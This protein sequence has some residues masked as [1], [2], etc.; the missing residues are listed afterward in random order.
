MARKMTCCGVVAALLLALCL[1]GIMAVAAADTPPDWVGDAVAEPDGYRVVNR[2]ERFANEGK[3]EE[4][5]CIWTC[6][7]SHYTDWYIEEYDADVRW[8]WAEQANTDDYEDVEG[9]GGF[10]S[11]AD[12]CDDLEEIFLYYYPG[13]LP[14]D[15]IPDSGHYW[16]D[17]TVTVYCKR[18]LDVCRPPAKE[19]TIWILDVNLETTAGGGP[20]NNDTGYHNGDGSQQD[21]EDYDHWADPQPD[22]KILPIALNNDDDDENRVADKYQTTVA[23]DKEGDLEC[24]TFQFT[25]GILKHKQGTVRVKISGD[26]PVGPV[27]HPK[28]KLW[29]NKRKGANQE[30]VLELYYTPPSAS[31]LRLDV[32]KMT[33]ITGDLT[34]DI[35]G[36]GIINDDEPT[37]VDQTR[38]QELGAFVAVNDDDDD[39][40][41]SVDKD[42]PEVVAGAPAASR[43]EDDLKEFYMGNL[44][45]TAINSE[46]KLRL[47]RS[48]AKIK[49]YDAETKGAGSLLVPHDGK[50]YREWDVTDSALPGWVWVEG[51]TQGASEL[52]IEYLPEDCPA[53]TAPVELDVVKVTVVTIALDGVKVYDPKLDGDPNGPTCDITYR[54]TGAP[55]GTK[56]ELTVVQDVAGTETVVNPAGQAPAAAA[57][58]LGRI[59]AGVNTATGYHNSQASSLRYDI[60]RG[61]SNYTVGDTL[62]LANSR[63]SNGLTFDVEDSLTPQG[64]TLHRVG[65]STAN[66]TLNGRPLNTAGTPERGADAEVNGINASYTVTIDAVVSDFTATRNKAPNAQGA[67][68]V[69]VGGAPGAGTDFTTTDGTVSFEI[70]R[71]TNPFVA[72]DN[73]TFDTQFNYVE[74]RASLAA[75][76]AAGRTPCNWSGAVAVTAC[77]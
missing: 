24:L 52:K 36:D 57:N 30:V 72:V 19:R 68:T 16:C 2:T 12:D 23:D 74:Y 56:G 50:D 26:D 8:S 10:G 54:V 39:R 46:G 38:E 31:E 55:A 17:G 43:D 28:L 29:K 34:T 71:G 60:I 65:G 48:N 18:P 9:E 5:D 27:L 75:P 3:A 32:V 53:A 64:A 25:H 47:T 1:A 6:E 22:S 11:E 7:A 42:D 51:F 14:T 73:F 41:G 62:R 15:G 49:V 66:G 40:D 70:V 67:G 59:E 20:G 33:V 58:Y 45:P 77:Q 4:G 35:D 69:R 76:G 21:R 63:L 61:A 13:V 37:D 44:E